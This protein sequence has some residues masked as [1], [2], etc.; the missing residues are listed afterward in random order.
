MDRERLD[1]WCEKGILGLVVAILVWGPLSAGAVLPLEFLVLQGLTIAVVA[2]WLVRIWIRPNY[3]LLWP[4]ICWAAIAFI[5]YAIA[6]YHFADIEYVARIEITR[7]VIYGFLFFVIIDNLHRQEAAQAITFVL[8]FLGMFISVYAVFEFFTDSPVVWHFLGPEQKPEQYM[9]RASGTYICPNNLAG[10]LEMI[11]P[12]GFA[13]TLTSRFKPTTRVFVGYA[14]IVMLAGLALTLSRGGWLAAGLALAVL[15]AILFRTRSSRLPAI[16]F[17]LFL[18]GCGLFF[19]KQTYSPQQRWQELF[20]DKARIDDFRYRDIRFSLWKP[21]VQMW[22][23]NVWWGV[24]PGHFDYRFPVYRPEVV[25]LRPGRVHNDYLNT[26]TDYGA[27][28]GLIL[29][30]LLACLAWGIT[31][32]WKFVRRSGDFVSKPSSR[33]SFVLGAG[34]GLLA[35]GIHSLVDFNMHVPANALIAV[36]LAAL[37]TGYSR[38]A[39]ESFWVTPNWLIRGL[40]TVVGVIGVMFL[41]QEGIKRFREE[42]FLINA[43]KAHR[44]A[45]KTAKEF[46]QLHAAGEVDS[47]AVEQLGKRG[48]TAMMLE[49]DAL[50]NAHGVEPM[51]F[52]T[53]YK[54]GQIFQNLSFQG[55]QDFRGL[56]QEALDWYARGIRLNPYDAYNYMRSGMCLDWIGRHD[57]AKPFFDKALSL[58]P[59]SYYVVAHYGV[60]FFYAGDD[61]EAKKWFEKSMKLADWR[62][63]HIANFFLTRIALRAPAKSSEAR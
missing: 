60:H 56:A 47:A 37:L 29:T 39:T 13:Y 63:N 18:I 35:I 12:I 50:K 40:V 31:R 3:R 51:N 8:I 19:F 16:V 53:T 10:F 54:L 43:L 4:P 2:L 22:N 1:F 7:I 55:S 44:I 52:E 46:E 58:D 48:H 23:E 28:G 32:T 26:L 27:V 59:K 25:Q 41:S 15:F 14:S 38:F 20:G 5:A 57:Q 9:K 17:V 36:A 33:A 30:A 62:D 49:I 42:G 21:A 45:E 11:L 24:G 6:R 34:V 61:D